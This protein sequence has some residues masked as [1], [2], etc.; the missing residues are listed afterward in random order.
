MILALWVTIANNVAAQTPDILSVPPPEH[1]QSL[2]LASSEMRKAAWS[3]N[4]SL[5]WGLF[6]TALTIAASDR[7]VKAYDHNLAVGFGLMT[8]GGF[9]VFQ[10]KSAG[11]DKRAAK[12][13]FNKH[14]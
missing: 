4:T 10:M 11:H 7:S 9:F 2:S 6:G 14:T 12:A 13:L 5:W 8:V 1:T 3:R